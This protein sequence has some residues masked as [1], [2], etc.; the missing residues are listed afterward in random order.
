MKKPERLSKEVVSLLLPRLKDE[1]KAFYFY[2]SAANWC[3]D[4]GFF[5]A[6]EYFNN[7]SNDELTHAKNIENYIVDW[8]VLPTLPNIDAP[9]ILFGSLYDIITQAYDIEYDLYEA[10]EKTSMD[11]FNT[12]DLCVFDFL[13]EYRKI[14]KDSVAEYSDMLNV[15]DRVNTD[16]K[17]EM[18]LLEE[19]LFG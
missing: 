1:F 9:T 7:E 8:N 4:K 3:K 16:S 6:A 15:L 19:K 10:Y 18:L 17:F 12:G 2:R 5:K 11:I 13:Q 14:Q